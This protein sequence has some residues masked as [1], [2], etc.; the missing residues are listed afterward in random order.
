MN[1]VFNPIHLVLITENLEAFKAGLHYQIFFTGPF[2]DFFGNFVGGGS[3]FITKYS[4]YGLPA[5]IRTNEETRSISHHVQVSLELM[6]WFTFGFACCINPIIAIPF[7]LTPLVNIG[8]ST[9]ATLWGIIPYTT[10]NFSLDNSIL[11]LQVGYRTGSIVVGF[12]QI[13]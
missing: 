2:G 6:K 8:L 11:L 7:I 5:K 9:L 13:D 4:L 1:T 3:T 10:G 12:F